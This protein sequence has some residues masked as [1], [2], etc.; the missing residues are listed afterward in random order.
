MLSD[1]PSGNSPGGLCRGASKMNR[2]LPLLVKRLAAMVPIMLLSLLLVFVL[3]DLAPGDPA[4]ASLGQVASAESRE[5]FREQHG[6]ND[7]L[8][9]RYV[10]FL[11]EALR[12][13]FGN[14]LVSGAPISSL[15]ANALPVTIQLTGL[16][17]LIAVT[18]ATMLGITAGVY[19][20]RWPDMAVRLFS[21]GL[22]GA[23]NF[24][25]GLLMINYFSIELGILPAG[26][27]A[28]LSDGFGD[29][30][31]S[32]ILPAVALAM[33]VGGILTRVVRSSMV[34][35]LEKDYVKTG[36]GAGLSP[37]TVIGNNVLR[38]AL[39]SPLTVLGLYIGYLLAG[40]VLIEVVFALPGIGRLLVDG[41]LDADLFQIRAIA[42][43]TVTL[44][45]I[46]NLV[47]D[48][49]YMV[50]NPKLDSA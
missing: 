4:F 50:L 33:P 10:R 14:A 38:N 34:E 2:I 48:I 40:A 41:V 6:L 15:M 22:I 12:G 16:A 44:F 19:R 25:L 47:V 29:W 30:A 3:I 28:P 26:G 17:M 45:L 9:I 31:R 5:M 36:Y 39:I 37:L 13:D 42:L 7:P 24:W 46:S 32:L 18:M 20:D 8:L 21:I 11:G 1:C 35:E 49:L 43:V 23:P 27:Y